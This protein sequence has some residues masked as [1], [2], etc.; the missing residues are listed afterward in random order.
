MAA[1]ITLNV[2]MRVAN[3][4]LLETI[5]PGSKSIDQA[6]VGGPAPGYVT[7]G[8]SEESV[9]LSELSTLGYCYL[10]N[11]DATNYVR[12]GFA[13]GVYGGRLN[14]GEIAVF[15]FN[16]GSSLFMIAN[17]AACKCLVKVFEN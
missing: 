2:S 7:I 6:A 9:T 14:A 1:E 11:L 13:T 17:T 5:Q 8:T 4:N 15:R 12:W 16:P 3:G 10:Q